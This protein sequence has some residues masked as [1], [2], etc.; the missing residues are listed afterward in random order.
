MTSNPLLRSLGG[1]ALNSGF[2]IGLT[3]LSGVVLARLL[4]AEGRG[5]YG[6]MLFISQFVVF[7]SSLAAFDGAA[8]EVRR[9]KKHADRFVSTIVLVSAPW[10]LFANAAAAAYLFSLG[11]EAFLHHEIAAIFVCINAS[12]FFSLV[13]C[14]YRCDADFVP[15]NR[16]RFWAAVLFLIAIGVY[17]IA[18]SPTAIAALLIF[19]AT[20][21]FT[22]VKG[23]F[24]HRRALFQSVD[25]KLGRVMIKSALRFLPATWAQ[26]FGNQ[27]DRLVVVWLWS[28]AALGHY[29]VAYSA[30]T[31]AIGLVTQAM[32][33]VLLPS[34][35]DMEEEQKSFEVSR[36]IRFSLLFAVAIVGGAFLVIP[37]AIPLV[38]GSTFGPAVPIALGLSIAFCLWPMRTILVEALR[39][40]GSG[41]KPFQMALAI[42]AIVAIGTAVHDL[43]Q[44]LLLCAWL[45]A[46]NAA[47]V[48]IGLYYLRR[49][50]IIRLDGSILPK[51]GDIVF[52]L[53]RARNLALNLMTK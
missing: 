51:M 13:L 11:E 27:I 42:I 23:L 34:L 12:F 41:A 18:L 17:A 14:I 30:I 39:S 50:Q 37:F 7:L 26:V 47:A 46:A 24:Q 49:E 25:R 5:E 16:N 45:G 15:I 40:T 33:V 21:L 29:F 31:A 38:Y 36:L 53:T 35:T 4:G 20:R 10:L 32:A 48:L 22:I 43:S 6:T 9:N 8:Y 28:G 2:L 3:F 44:P 52:L 19:G 1:V